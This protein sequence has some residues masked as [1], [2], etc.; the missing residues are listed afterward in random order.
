M[1]QEVRV[2]SFRCYPQDA[3][4]LKALA[5]STHRTV[6]DV[7]RLLVQQAVVREPDIR[8]QFAREEKNGGN[9]R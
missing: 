1:G 7:L 2:V 5:S 9:Q 4:R 3:E 6:S 8:L